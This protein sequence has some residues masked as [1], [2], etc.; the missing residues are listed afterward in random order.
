M[1]A[2]TI[3]QAHS[4][5]AVCWLPANVPGGSP[6]KDTGCSKGCLIQDILQV[7]LHAK[8]YTSIMKNFNQNGS[9]C[10]RQTGSK[11]DMDFIK[12]LLRAALQLHDQDN[13]M[14]LVKARRPGT[15]TRPHYDPRC[16]PGSHPAVLQQHASKKR[17][18]WLNRTQCRGMLSIQ[19]TTTFTPC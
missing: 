15:C 10:A 13:E 2:K 4:H 8:N 7:V 16:V 17:P 18:P 1:A 3:E 9:V 14:S 19:R 6:G 11:P 12:S 5:A